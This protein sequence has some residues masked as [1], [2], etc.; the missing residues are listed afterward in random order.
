VLNPNYYRSS[1]VTVV[2]KRLYEAGKNVVSWSFI[3]CGYGNEASDEDLNPFGPGI[4][5]RCINVMTLN[6]VC[7]FWN[8]YRLVNHLASNNC[9]V[10]HV[11][12]RRLLVVAWMVRCITGIRVVYTG[13]LTYK[14][15]NLLRPFRVD[16]AVGIS[17][18]VMADVRYSVSADYYCKIG[19]PADFDW[20]NADVHHKSPAVITIARLATVKNHEY[21]LNSWRYVLHGIPDAALLLVGEGELRERL[22]AQAADLGISNSVK[23][24]GYLSDWRTIA[25]TCRFAILPSLVEGHPVAGREAAALKL[26]TLVTD[27]DG[28]RDTIPPLAKLRNRAPL[29]EPVLFAEFITEWLQ[30]PDMVFADGK[31]FYDYHAALNSSSAVFSRYLKYCWVPAK[32][33]T[34]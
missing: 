4:H 27:V 30:Q 14:K 16:V 22:E 19:N 10:L 15:T 7:F 29:N 2:I 12:H 28:S 17:E 26:P 34:I 13:H 25:A 3:T 1:G 31:R 11:H 8:L 23:F 33:N 9:N 18:A 6:P 21:L 24:L 32:I 20:S 5:A